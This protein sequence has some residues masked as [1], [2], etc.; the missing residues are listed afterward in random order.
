VVAVALL[1]FLVGAAE[2]ISRYRDSPGRALTRVPALVYIM[3][4]VGAAVAA[5]GLI[6][7]YGLD[8]LA[9]GPAGH[10]RRWS[11]V[12]AAGL[13]ALAVLRLSFFTLRAG[14]TDVPIGPA[15][16]LQVIL[17]AADRSVDRLT[18]AERDL[19]VGR[20]MRGVSFEKASAA[21]PAYCLALMQ[22]LSADEQADLARQ[23]NAL[24]GAQF[25]DGIKALTL[26]LTLLNLVGAAVLA[27][28]VESLGD[29]IMT[30]PAGS[31]P[32]PS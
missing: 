31:A 19:L 26:G 20:I 1:G 8:I 21:L 14:D 11:E 17:D 10:A 4:N 6:R 9:P 30:E 28:A 3:V 15:A 16:F 12:L 27:S 13:G 24:R 32:D 2:L 23:V 29:K 5:L 25:D 7:A 18:A 22:N